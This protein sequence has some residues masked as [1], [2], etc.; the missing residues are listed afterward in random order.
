MGDF[1][2]IHRTACGQI[3]GRV[4]AAICEL[5][6]QF[7]KMPMTEHE[8]N[9]TREQMN[10]VSQYPHVLGVIDGSLI[11]IQNP[12]NFKS[13]CIMVLLVIC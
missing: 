3:I 1:A 2:G 6:R 10:S 4:T 9:L 5:R 13:Y 8:Q 12:D 11:P 7:I